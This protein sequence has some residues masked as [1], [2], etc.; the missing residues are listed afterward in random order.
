MLKRVFCGLLL[1]STNCILSSFQV[2]ECHWLLCVINVLER[3]I[4]TIIPYS[5]DSNGCHAASDT[6]LGDVKHIFEKHILDCEICPDWTV[7]ASI[8]LSARLNPPRLTDDNTEDYTIFIYLYAWTV[9]T[10]AA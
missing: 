1:Y 5:P 9:L 3:I 2:S 10:G 4:G 7:I 6:V 8:V